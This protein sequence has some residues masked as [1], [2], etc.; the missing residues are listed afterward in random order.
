MIYL[1]FVIFM[2]WFCTQIVSLVQLHIIPLLYYFFSTF[3]WSSPYPLFNFMVIYLKIDLESVFYYFHVIL[4]HFTCI[5]LISHTC[6]SLLDCLIVSLQEVIANTHFISPFSGWF[7]FLHNLQLQL[8]HFIT[9]QQ[10]VYILLH[11]FVPK[12]SLK[13]SLFTLSSCDIK[14]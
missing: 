9:F 10:H 4:V 12:I 13:F 14:F 5:F 2:V 8:S 11:W 1:D 3:L 6:S 7:T